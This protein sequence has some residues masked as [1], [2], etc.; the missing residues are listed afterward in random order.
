M[1]LTTK[2]AEVIMGN[3][4]IIFLNRVL[5]NEKIKLDKQYRRFRLRSYLPYTQEC[6]LRKQFNMHISD[7]IKS[8]FQTENKTDL[9]GIVARFESSVIDLAIA[10]SG[11]NKTHAAQLLKI[12]KATLHRKIAK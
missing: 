2:E 10:A 8:L 4:N 1:K 6:R 9:K 11:G 12:G 7:T 5:R 3:Y